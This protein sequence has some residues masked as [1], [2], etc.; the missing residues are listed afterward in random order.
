MIFFAPFQC[1]RQRAAAPTLPQPPSGPPGLHEDAPSRP[2]HGHR[3]DRGQ[4]AGMAGAGEAG[5]ARAS[6]ATRRGAAVRGRRGRARTGWACARCTGAWRGSR[7]GAGRSPPARG[8]GRRRRPADGRARSPT[9]CMAAGLRARPCLAANHGPRAP[10]LPG[11]SSP[12][13]CNAAWRPACPP[14]A[15]PMVGGHASCRAR[16]CLA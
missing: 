10:A 12:C 13:V 4:A 7:A 11:V 14:N 15:G 16:V 2:L 9:A 6:L 3:P 1:P 5:A 8:A